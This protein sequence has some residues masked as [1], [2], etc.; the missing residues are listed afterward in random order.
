PG[1]QGPEGKIG[2]TGPQ[3]PR[4]FEGPEGPQFVGQY[5]FFSQSN[6]LNATSLGGGLKFDDPTGISS[7][8]ILNDTGI[9]S[10]LIKGVY[11]LN[12]YVYFP[13]NSTVNTTLSLQVDNSTI[14]GT[15][16]KVVKTNTNVPYIA[17][18]QAIFTVTDSF[19]SALRISS[20]KTFSISEENATLAS[21]S[22]VQLQA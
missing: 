9:I 21:I 6:T 4:G 18:G 16:C 3:G 13:A 2:P 1:I 22:I 5:A 19:G 12:Y 10:L 17:S 7:P 20:S 14:P 8:R 15:V 11:K